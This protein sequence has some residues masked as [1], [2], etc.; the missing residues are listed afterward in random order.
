[1][2]ADALLG[3]AAIS[4]AA[5]TPATTRVR[6]LMSPLRVEPVTDAAHCMDEARLTI[7]LQLLTDARDM[8]LERVGP[9][10]CVRR[11]HRLGELGVG[12]EPAAVAHERGQDPELET[13]EAELL[14]APFG[15]SLA[16]VE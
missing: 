5:R 9:G 11:P 2:L 15:G 7:R 14:A 16:Q 12:D 3:A 8:H 13:G 10:P 4:P 6:N 1:M